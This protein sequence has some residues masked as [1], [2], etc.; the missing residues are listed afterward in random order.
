[1]KA[2][3]VL[4]GVLLFSGCIC[5][6]GELPDFS[7]LTGDTD[8]DGEDC[9]SPYIAYGT[10]CCLDANGNSVCD[11][12]EPMDDTTIPMPPAL[13]DEATSTTMQSTTTSQ[14]PTTTMAA[15]T[16]TLKSTYECVRNAG[17]EP[18]SVLYLYSTRCGDNFL[19]TASTV[20]HRTGV[21]F[22]KLKIGGYIDESKIKVMEC[23]YGGY[24]EGNP[25]FGECPKLLCPRTG[26]TKIL[27]GRSSATVLS[28]MTGFAKDCK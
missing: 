4:V 24:S 11:N 13:P 22:T 15:T 27:T 28:Q 12:D 1:M 7:E 8:D 6:G 18:D 9:P 26:E 14:A 25:L 5:C 3:V 16:T 17:Y 20:E 10:G 23:F 2:I 21:D 19:S